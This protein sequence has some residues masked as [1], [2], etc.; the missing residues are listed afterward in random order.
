MATVSAVGQI[1]TNDEDFAF[2]DT[3][4]SLNLFFPVVP[5]D[6]D[7]PWMKMSKQTDSSQQLA[8]MFMSALASVQFQDVTRQQIEQVIDALKRLDAHAALLASRLDQFEDP[9]FVMQPLSEHLDQIYSSYVMDS[10]RDTHH[11]ATKSGAATVKAG[12]KI[13]LF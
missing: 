6:N 9:H 1:V 7:L 4:D 11:A 8:D 12:P 3:L 13:E 10:Q 2:I 5:H